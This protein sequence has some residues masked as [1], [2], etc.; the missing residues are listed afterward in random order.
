[1]DSLDRTLRGHNV[2][3]MVL[4]NAST[5]GTSKFVADLPIVMRSRIPVSVD[6]QDRNL[7]VAAGRQKLADF[8]EGDIFLFLDSDVVIADVMD[9]NWLK[10]IT[11]AFADEAVGVAGTAGSL[12]MFATDEH[13]QPTIFTPSGEGKCD[14][15][16]GWCM[17]VRGTLFQHVAFDMQF[18]PR[19]EEDADLCLQVRALG[20]DVVQITVDGLEHV[21]GNDGAETVNRRESLAKFR[22]KWEGKGVVKMEGGW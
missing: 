11:A 7:G 21:P 2:E 19:W 5:D 16:S 12:V 9:T 14:V 1:M 3:L 6:Q 22:A 8:A 15:V 17:A 20:F 10:Q 18:N 13:Q 4:D